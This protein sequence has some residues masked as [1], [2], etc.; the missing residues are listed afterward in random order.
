MSADLTLT[1]KNMLQLVME[2]ELINIVVLIGSHFA[3][4]NRL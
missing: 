3:Q 4:S 2:S 1:L